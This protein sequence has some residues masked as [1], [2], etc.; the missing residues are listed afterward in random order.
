MNIYRNYNMTVK[1]GVANCKVT[2]SYDLYDNA[3]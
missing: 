1:Y 2:F 3:N